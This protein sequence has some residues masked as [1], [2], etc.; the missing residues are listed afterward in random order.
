MWSITRRTTSCRLSPNI[1]TFKVA[2]EYVLDGED[3]V[4]RVLGDSIEYP[5]K[6][7]NPKNG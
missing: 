2:V 1:E 4:A 6:V 3:F 7:K 5:E